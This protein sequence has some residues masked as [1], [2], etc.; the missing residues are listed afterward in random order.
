MLISANNPWKLNISHGAM[1]LFNLNLPH[2][3]Y[4]PLNFKIDYKDN[5]PR[6]FLIHS[7]IREEF[8]LSLGYSTY[9]DEELG[10]NLV[11]EKFG[12]VV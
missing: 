5:K 11:L 3:S 7:L 8:Y 4:L 2:N 9:D 10:S 6:Q 1:K 12:K